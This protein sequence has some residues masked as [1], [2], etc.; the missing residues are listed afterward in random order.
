MRKI[1]LTSISIV[2]ILLSGCNY[3]RTFPLY[4]EVRIEHPESIQLFDDYII[5]LKEEA[6]KKGQI[7][8]GTKIYSKIKNRI[9]D[10]LSEH[11][12]IS[13]EIM[14]ALGHFRIIP[15]INTDEV[16]LL[17]GQPTRIIKS[18]NGGETWVYSGDRSKIEEWDWYYKW[19]KLKFEGGILK[20]IEIQ[21]IDIWK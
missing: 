11:K 10:Y 15:G 5:G 2:I 20:D 12:N 18:K 8:Y 3:F 1:Y 13:S 16:L 7:A 19:G 17:V 9:T 4:S 14:N 21:S 6:I